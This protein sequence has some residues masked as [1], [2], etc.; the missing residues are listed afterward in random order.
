M[1]S[2][3]RLVLL[4]GAALLAS[5]P[6]CQ[7]DGQGA[8]STL[9][10]ASDWPRTARLGAADLEVGMSD[11]D[12]FAILKDRQSENVSAVV[13]DGG[14]SEH[15]SAAQFAGSVRFLHRAAEMA[16]RLGMRAV[17]Y[18]PSLEVLTRDAATARTTMAREH[19]DWLQEGLGGQPNVL[20]GT[21]EDRVDPGTESAWMSPNG[22]YR[23]YFLARVRAL[24]RTA[25]DGVWMDAPVYL[26]SGAGWP[27]AEPA[28][29]AAF[30]AWEAAHD[31]GGA[32]AGQMPAAADTQDPA[33]RRW[34]R[35]RHENLADFVEDVRRA[36]REVKP[37]FV[38]AV[39]N[40]PLDNVEATSA[41]LD[42]TFR[43]DGEGLLTVFEVDS[44][45]STKGMQYASVEDFSNKIAMFKWAR[46]CNRGRPSWAFSYGNQPLDAGLVMAA[47]VA[48]G[49]APLEAKT[50]ELVDSVGADFRRRWFGF[51]KDHTD[52]LLSTPRLARVGIW[53]SAASRDYQDLPLGGTYGM[54]VAVDPPVDDPDWW[55]TGEEDSALRKPHLGGWRGAAHTLTT[56]GIPW[57]VV[58]EPGDPA[59]ELEGLSLLWLP[60]VAALTAG[61]A[62]II[63][64]FVERG[65]V[66]L[67]TGAVPG[68]FDE[69]GSAR[70]RSVLGD[71]FGMGATPA[72]RTR[73]VGA[74]VVIYQ[75]NTQASALFA[76]A[77]DVDKA[78]DALSAV[79]PLLRIHVP[80][81]LAWE[82]PPGVLVEMAR[83]APE[84]HLL[85][86]VNYSGLRQPL[87][88]APLD[89]PVRYRV[90][91]GWRVVS[92][93]VAT[94][95]PG[96]A[97]GPLAVSEEGPGLYRVGVR[98]DQFAL[99]TLRL[100]P[101]LSPPPPPYTAPRFASAAWRE[102]A[103]S[104]LAFVLRAMRDPTLPEPW[105]FG[106]FTNLLDDPQTPPDVYPSGHYVTAEHMGL[107]LRA[108][109]CMG[110]ETAY[111]QAY[112]YV[113]EL[114]TS[115]LYHVVSW[116]MDPGARGP[117]LSRADDAPVWLVGNAPA[118]DLRVIR[119]LLSGPAQAGL[120]EA[121][122]L[123]AALLRGLYWTSVTDRDHD[124]VV[125]FPAYRGGLLGSA[126]SWAE[127]DAPAMNPPAVATGQGLLSADPVPVDYQDIETLGLAAAIDPRWTGVIASATRLLLDAEI[128]DAAGA[129]T[130]LFWNG[131]D[132]SLGFTGDVENRDG[133]QGKHLKT[134]QELRTALHLA[135]AAALPEG[136]LDPATRAAS[137]AAAGRALAFWKRL[138]ETRRRVP[139]YL[140]SAGEDVPDCPAGVA[141][142]TCLARG[143][144]NLYFGE[145]RIY[146]LLARLALRLG[147]PAL[148]AAL[149]DAQI[150]PDRVTATGDP[151]YGLIGVST[152]DEGDAEAWNVLESVLTMCLAAGGQ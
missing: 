81:D 111:R 10:P 132:P 128:R 75:P 3:T 52:E 135:A 150:V 41:G 25:L 123:A 133:A 63:R 78:A 140:T 120:P 53:Y 110:D 145:A 8:G 141:D 2:P 27:G 14:L 130:G 60:S 88:R 139:Q 79:E 28:G 49:N 35:W 90:P 19:P 55:A 77:G 36:G 148:A 106:V 101:I 74:G 112:R 23:D 86:V 107:L 45:S 147:D 108:A 121:R 12:V 76:E 138:Y 98:V 84:R 144:D 72:P 61:S 11:A 59:R 16:H 99:V 70:V 17:V 100:A 97:V 104:G 105:S 92:A 46:A 136:R 68:G 83:P 124:E 118:D 69:L 119:G 103:E 4:A 39:E 26:D 129:P 18:Y 56:M 137:R 122:A 37:T 67:A 73:Q 125:E 66:V 134:I 58:T 151:R 24:A 96:G 91:D 31:A 64:A 43:R 51:I 1:P 40:F 6:A 71:L 116:A 33:F 22:G 5:G 143:L 102:A 80:E 152:A 65:G 127:T 30:R 7:M 95:D 50:P 142:G 47:A 149:I 109:A 113:R 131:L 38:T 85:Y 44:V 62:E 48:T 126:W 82:G 146:A 20:V 29:R 15:Q 54:F 114:M 94:P 117:L 9:E 34:L 21:L 13:L 115:R 93:E 57:K 32:A 89:L 42:A 87:V